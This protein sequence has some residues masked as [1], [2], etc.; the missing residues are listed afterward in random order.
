M[1]NIGFWPRQFSATKGICQFVAQSLSL[2][3]NAAQ[4]PLQLAGIQQPGNRTLH[5]P[6]DLHSLVGHG[7]GEAVRDRSGSDHETQ[8]QGRADGL[9]EGA[10]QHGLVRRRRE[11]RDVAGPRRN[12]LVVILVLE[13]QRAVPSGEGQQLCTSRAAQAHAERVVLCGGQVN[14][15]W[16]AWAS[17]SGVDPS[18]LS[19]HGYGEDRCTGGGEDPGR[20]RIPRVFDSA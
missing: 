3:S 10:D 17:E 8:A 12:E 19:V 16:H 14:E 1:S 7:I 5:G 6:G 18:A 9:G 4:V 2:P 15:R 11:Q 13:H 20:A